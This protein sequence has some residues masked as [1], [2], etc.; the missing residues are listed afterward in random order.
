MTNHDFMDLTFKY[1]R[2]CAVLSSLRV[3]L[4]IDRLSWSKGRVLVKIR[5]ENYHVQQVS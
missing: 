3:I 2:Y 4:P 1:R 5:E